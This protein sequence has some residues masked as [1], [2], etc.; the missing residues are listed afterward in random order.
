MSSP[1]CNRLGCSSFSARRF[2]LSTCSARRRP[3]QLAA[4][5]VA[6]DQVIWHTVQA[7]LGER[8]A[9]LRDARCLAFLPARGRGSWPCARRTRGTGRVL[10]SWLATVRISRTQHPLPRDRAA[11]GHAAQRPCSS[12]IPVRPGLGWRRCPPTLGR[13]APGGPLLT[14]DAGVMVFQ[15]VA[16]C[17]TRSATTPRWMA[18]ATR[19]RR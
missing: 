13:L 14:G 4:Y 19:K 2:A 5:A 11:A 6:R 12:P 17:W 15:V 16:Q 9:K 10:A 7:F 3:S 18:G 8:G 1:T